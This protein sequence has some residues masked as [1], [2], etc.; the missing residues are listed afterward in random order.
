MA[1]GRRISGSVDFATIHFYSH[2]VTSALRGSRLTEAGAAVALLAV[3]S[4]TALSFL[5]G[6]SEDDACGASSSR[7]DASAHDIRAGPTTA[8]SPHC[9]ICHLWQSASRF[10][11]PS[12]PSTL[13]PIVDFGPIAKPPVIA[14]DLAVIASRPARAPP[15]I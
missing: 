2:F 12:L 5:H 10:R 1:P 7:H 9:S 15:V 8:G 11:G 14:P 4:M 6:P 3:L 13:I